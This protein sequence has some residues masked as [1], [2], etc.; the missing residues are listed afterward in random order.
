MSIMFRGK[1][2]MGFLQVPILRWCQFMYYSIGSFNI[3][4]GNPPGIWLFG[5]LLFKFPTTRTNMPLK[6]PTLG[7]IQVI[8][9]LHPKDI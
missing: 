3:P 9:Y 6:C 2:I 7:S 4:P 5:K 8:K 1:S